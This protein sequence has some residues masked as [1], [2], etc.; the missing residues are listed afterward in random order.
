M[1]YG[2]LRPGAEKAARAFFAQVRGTQT[3]IPII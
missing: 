2:V 1:G 3:P